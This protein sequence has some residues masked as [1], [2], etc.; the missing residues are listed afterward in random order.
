MDRGFASSLWEHSSA[1]GLQLIKEEDLATY[2][3]QREVDGPDGHSLCC[4]ETKVL[5]DKLFIRISC[6]PMASA[7]A[8]Y[9][10]FNWIATSASLLLPW[11]HD[12]ERIRL[13]WQENL[14]RRRKL[15]GPSL[16][17]VM[18]QLFTSLRG[19]ARRSMTN[20]LA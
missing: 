19:I 17:G 1:N 18:F 10:D 2:I 7:V 13:K 14:L 3:R 12:D 4:S 5:E 9:V 15:E 16:A 8:C 6:S 20:V 11:F